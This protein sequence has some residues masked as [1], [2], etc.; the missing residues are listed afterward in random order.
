MESFYYA[1]NNGLKDI[2][3]RLENAESALYEG[4]TGE[5]LELIRGVREEIR[6]ETSLDGRRI[7]ISVRNIHERLEEVYRGLSSINI[8]WL[9]DKAGAWNSSLADD[10]RGYSRELQKLLEE[11]EESYGI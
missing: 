6:G 8:E 4:E 5:A 2:G 9:L 1:V 3:E 10:V 7:K 11:M